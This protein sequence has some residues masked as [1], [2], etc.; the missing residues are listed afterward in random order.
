VLEAASVALVRP[1]LE[2]AWSS[3]APAK[4]RNSQPGV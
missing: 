1:L 2:Q 4:L 3:V